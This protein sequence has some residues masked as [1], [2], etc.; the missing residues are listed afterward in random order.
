MSVFNTIMSNQYLRSTMT[1]TLYNNTNYN[2]DSF[3]EE[4]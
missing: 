1:G 3:G 2:R 4:H